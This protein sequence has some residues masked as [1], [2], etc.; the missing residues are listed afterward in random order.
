MTGRKEA[1]TARSGL[2]IGPR[3]LRTR[4]GGLALAFLVV[5]CAFSG[6]GDAPPADWETAEIDSPEIREASGLVQSRRWPGV[7]WTH[8]DSGDDP[9]IFAIDAEGALLAQFELI[10]VENRDWEDIATDADGNLYVGDIGNNWNSREDLAV[11]RVREPDPKDGDGRLEV[12][13]VIRFA[14]ADQET[15]GDRTAMNF[16]CEA[17]FWRAGRLYVFTKHRSDTATQLYAIDPEATGRQ[18]VRPIA[19]YELGENVA[20]LMG[21][22]TGADIT[23]ESDRVALLTYRGAYLFAWPDDA[24]TPK[25]PVARLPLEIG[26]TQQAES[27]AW[28]GDELVIGNEKGRLFRIPKPFETATEAVAEAGPDPAP[29]GQ[30]PAP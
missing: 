27:I 19:R 6:P 20:G 4:T 14:F 24:T 12:E 10:G 8:N 23:P 15:L 28:D 13:H 11:L 1:G 2:R 9:R 26:V 16:D 29:S 5:G 21:N 17:L 30:P 18:A 7:Y 22:T 3:P 25:G